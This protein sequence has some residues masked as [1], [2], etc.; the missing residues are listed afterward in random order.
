MNTFMFRAPLLAGAILVAGGAATATAVEPSSGARLEESP[1]PLGY[2]IDIRADDVRS[3][4]GDCVV[5]GTGVERATPECNPELLA[6]APPLPAEEEA[7]M[8]E[9]GG[10][11]AAAPTPMAEPRRISL[12]T[13]ATF[14]FDSAELTDE[15]KEQLDQIVDVSRDTESWRVHVTG[16]ADRIGADEYNLDLSLRRAEAVKEY[17]VTKGMSSD[18]IT[19]SGLGEQAPVVQCEGLRG[20][21][22]IS[23]L[24]P[25]RRSDIEFAGFEQAPAEGAPEGMS[26]A[27]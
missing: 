1:A 11:A 15:G 2:V 24:R 12:D 4:T 16:H 7:A 25:N 23:C 14:A 9:T 8:P 27:P 18:V 21:E 20:D 10:A 19:V 22:L 6:Q 26:P 3:G 5:S 17:L 13:D